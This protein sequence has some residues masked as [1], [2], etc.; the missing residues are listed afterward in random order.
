MISDKKIFEYLD[1]R[2]FLNNHFKEKKR[3]NP[4][5]S[6]RSVAIRLEVNPGTIVRVLQG[7]RNISLEL[8]ERFTKILKLSKKETK[9]FELLVTFNQAKSME[10]KNK[11]LVQLVKLRDKSLKTLDKEQF[12]Y[13]TSWHTIVIKEILN[14]YRFTGNYEEL[15][16]LV[17]PPITALQARQSIELLKRLRIIECGK[18]DVYILK[19]T[20][21]TTPESWSS[22]AINNF[23]HEM[24]KLAS[25]A[26]DRYPKDIRDFST[27]SMSI[28]SDGLKK[29]KDRINLFY[30]DVIDIVQEDSRPARIYELN[31]Q[32]FPLSNDLS[33]KKS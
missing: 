32:L 11:C 15:A 1:Y 25:E 21:L 19:D 3:I 2:D 28:S 4:S 27:A 13:F 9:Y 12:E 29:I 23:Q 6:L 16:R 26:L 14:I 24:I 30:Q 10:D 7:T 22:F 18:D 33:R 8:A 31:I 20:L 5:F 17:S